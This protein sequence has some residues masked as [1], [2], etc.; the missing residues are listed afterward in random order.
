M[1]CDAPNHMT[2]SNISMIF[3]IVFAMSHITQLIFSLLG[4]TIAVFFMMPC[5]IGEATYV[6]VTEKIIDSSADND[7]EVHPA[8]GYQWGLA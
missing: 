7:S 3:L 1:T 6:L 8:T 5:P 2:A 4:D